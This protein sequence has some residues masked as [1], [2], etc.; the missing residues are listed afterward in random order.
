MPR[1][2]A[3]PGWKGHGKTRGPSTRRSK[4][5]FYRVSIR[6]RDDVMAK[7]LRMCFSHPRGMHLEDGTAALLSA[8]LADIPLTPTDE[9]LFRMWK[10]G[11]PKDTWPEALQQVFTRLFGRQEHWAETIAQLKK[12]RADLTPAELEAYEKGEK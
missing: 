1:Q 4:R 6:L 2:P 5:K 10:R 12:R 3:Q 8:I 7:L 9:A 11:R